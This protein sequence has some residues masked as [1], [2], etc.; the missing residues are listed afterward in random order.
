MNLILM[1]KLITILFFNSVILMSAIA[2]LNKND[3]TI[4]IPFTIKNKIVLFLLLGVVTT[5]FFTFSDGNITFKFILTDFFL[6]YLFLTSYIDYHTQLIYSFVNYVLIFIGGCY[7]LYIILNN[8]SYYLAVHLAISIALV[9]LIGYLLNGYGSGDTEF[10]IAISFF[11]ISF[12]KNSWVPLESMLLI[13]FISSLMFLVIHLKDYDF[14]T[15]KTKQKYA[16]AP[17][18]TFATVIVTFMATK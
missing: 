4:F 2:I 8:G 6:L 5:L 10:L 3:D 13:I 12:N 7:F 1:I 9:L 18:I 11:V 17:Y 16:F 15:K 14:K